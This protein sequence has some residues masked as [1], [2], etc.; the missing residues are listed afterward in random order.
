MIPDGF[1]DLSPGKIAS[2]VTYLEMREPPRGAAVSP[3]AVSKNKLSLRLVETPRLAWYRDLYRRAGSQWLW[4][5]RLEMTDEQ[6]SAVLNSPANELFVAEHEGR[7]VGMAELDRSHPPDVE[8]TF[9]GLFPDAIGK[10][11]GR[12]FMSASARSGMDRL[13]SPRLVA[14][15]QSRRSGCAT[16]LCQMRIP[17]L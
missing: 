6:L 3:P 5:S 13:G 15:L 12:P 9:F 2:V 10:G 1:T 14:H 11:L 16:L 8:I 17:S 4:F 7:E